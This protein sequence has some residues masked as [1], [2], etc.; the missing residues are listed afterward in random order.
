MAAAAS[1]A[2]SREPAHTRELVLIAQSIMRLQ[3]SGALAAEAS[4][5]RVYAAVPPRM[6]REMLPF[7]SRHDFVIDTH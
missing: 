2:S 3:S 5:G 1:N 4:D 7:S 6:A